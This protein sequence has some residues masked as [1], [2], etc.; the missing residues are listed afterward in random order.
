MKGDLLVLQR[1]FTPALEVYRKALAEFYRKFPSSHDPPE[2]LLMSI[3]S[4]KEKLADQ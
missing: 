4:V 3:S 1:S 2:Y